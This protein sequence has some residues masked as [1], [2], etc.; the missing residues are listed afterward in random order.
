MVTYN[1]WD[2]NPKDVIPISFDT[3]GGMAAGT[4]SYLRNLAHAVAGNSVSRQAHVW[5]RLNESIH[6]TLVIGQGRVI[7]EL[8]RRARFTNGVQSGLLG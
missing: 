7:A 3:Y 1:K 5:R 6:V 2:I 4:E 8:I